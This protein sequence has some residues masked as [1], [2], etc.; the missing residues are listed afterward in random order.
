MTLNAPGPWLVALTFAMYSCQWLSIIGFLPTIYAQAGLS[1]ATAGMLAAFVSALPD[2]YRVRGLRG[3]WI[4]REA[5]RKLLPAHIV[6][7][8]KIGFR[9]PV[10]AWFRGPLLEAVLIVLGALLL[11]RAANAFASLVSRRRQPVLELPEELRY[12]RAIERAI[13]RTVI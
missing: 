3:K 6:D 4:L 2:R 13:A 12:R 10:S 5:A 9:V 8:P 7:R 1:V 11:S